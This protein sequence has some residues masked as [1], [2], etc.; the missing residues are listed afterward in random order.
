MENR[1]RVS[2]LDKFTHDIWACKLSASNYE[3]V[4]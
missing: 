3:N 4:Q 2:A 1:Y